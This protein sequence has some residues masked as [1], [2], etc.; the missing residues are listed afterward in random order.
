MM[1][2]YNVL[3]FLMFAVG[4]SIGFLFNIQKNYKMIAILVI[5]G[6]VIG[7]VS[8]VVITDGLV[9]GEDNIYDIFGKM[10]YSKPYPLIESL[11]CLFLLDPSRKC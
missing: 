7:T 3:Y 11:S 1:F 5:T 6:L 2:I 8:H 4:F 10:T 9:Y